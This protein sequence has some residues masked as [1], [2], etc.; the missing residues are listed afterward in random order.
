MAPE[1]AC[2]GMGTEAFFPNRGESTEAAREVCARC[3]VSRECLTASLEEALTHGV[4][5]GLSQRGR[6]VLRRGSAA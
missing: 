1:A 4:W 2:R 6:R 5:G 3:T